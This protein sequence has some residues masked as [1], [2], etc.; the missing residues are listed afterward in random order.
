[1]VWKLTYCV[2]ADGVAVLFSPTV[3]TTV[4]CTVCISFVTTVGTVAE[5]TAGG[6]AVSWT[7]VGVADGTAVVGSGGRGMES[8]GV[9][10]SEPVSGVGVAVVRTELGGIGTFVVPVVAGTG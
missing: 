2:A 4:A 1:M 7:G 8:V 10:V 5:L 6:D 9:L 3:G